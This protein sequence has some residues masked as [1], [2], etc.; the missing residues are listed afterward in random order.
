VAKY[1][2]VA[3]V[4]L[5][6]GWAGIGAAAAQQPCDEFGGTVDGDQMCQVHVTTPAYGIDMSFPISD[7]ANTAALDYLRQTRDGFINVATGPGVLGLPYELDVTTRTYDATVPPGRTHSLVFEIYQN[8]GGA[9]PDTWFKAFTT[10]VASNT[11]APQDALTFEQLFA[12]GTHPLDVIYPAV[13]AD[14]QRQLG[15]AEPVDPSSGMDPSKYQNFAITDTDVI[16]F[17]G[18]GELM[19]Q[20]AGAVQVQIPRSALPPLLI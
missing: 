11:A 16:F 4:V 7:R 18:Q 12:P 6:L 17:F 13:Q 5:A 20:A 1:L 10:P 15:V 2:S 3:L 14:L 19:A 8:V 9:H